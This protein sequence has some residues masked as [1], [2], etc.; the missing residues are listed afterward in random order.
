MCRLRRFSLTLCSRFYKEGES[1]NILTQVVIDNLYVCGYRIMVITSVSQTDDVGSIPSIRS[2]HL[3]RYIPCSAGVF[4]RGTVS[5]ISLLPRTITG[6]LLEFQRIFFQYK[7]GA[8]Y[9]KSSGNYS[10]ETDNAP[11]LYCMIRS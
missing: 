7:Y 2:G 8:L 9:G 3:S 5:C 6:G 4:S 11:F 1:F 10:G